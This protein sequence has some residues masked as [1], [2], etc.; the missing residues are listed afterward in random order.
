MY[1]PKVREIKEALSSF[2]SAPY[3]SK[4]PKGGYTPPEEYRG[5]PKYNEADCVGCGT[6]VQVCPNTAIEIIDDREKRI[7]TLRVD[8]ASCMQCGQ[9][10]EKCITGL[11]IQ[12]SEHYS[13]S[14][15]DLKA[16]EVFESVDKQL[17][18]CEACGEAIACKDHLS[19]VKERLGAKAYAHPTLMLETQE[20]FFETEASKPKERIRREDFMKFVCAK[21]RQKV[22]LSD[23]F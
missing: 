4:F 3:T 10:T 19:W 7:R 14:V 5:F 1:L 21:C 9:C 18:I 23:E 8:Y 16:A 6:C 2:F 15:S 11:G 12:P 22:V 17:V 20:E 13:L